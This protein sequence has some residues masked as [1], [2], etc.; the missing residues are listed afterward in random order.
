[1]NLRILYITPESKTYLPGV[2]LKYLSIWNSASVPVSAEIAK[3]KVFIISGAQFFFDNFR[4]IIPTNSKVT[5]I[6]HCQEIDFIKNHESFLDSNIVFIPYEHCQLLLPRTIK[7]LVK[8]HSEYQKITEKNHELE[9]QIDTLKDMQ[10]GFLSNIT[11][12]LR[13]PLNSIIGYAELIKEEA[14]E[15]QLENIENDIKIIQTAGGQL[16]H[17]I[18]KIINLI[19]LSA[20]QIPLAITAITNQQLLKFFSE[21]SPYIK[22]EIHGTISQIFSDFSILKLALSEVLENALKFSDSHKV[23]VKLESMDNKLH[24]CII[25]NGIGIPSEV[26]A[27]IKDIFLKGDYSNSRKFGGIGIGLSLTKRALLNLCGDLK[28]ESQVRKGTQV[29]LTIPNL[30][31]Y[32]SS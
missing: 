18:D 16:R 12:E 1:M 19:N 17:L 28:L 10:Q 20:D 25:D 6:Y 3:F 26:V 21:Y 4:D 23:T 24:I 7:Q 22:L 8:R 27:G 15:Q 5:I 9:K 31:H 13:T 14:S 32:K 29:T 2:D 11:H 30:T